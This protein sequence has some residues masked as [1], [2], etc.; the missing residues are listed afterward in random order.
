[1]IEKKSS[2]CSPP[3]AT[4]QSCCNG[5]SQSPVLTTSLS[6]HDRFGNCM[7]R[8]SN[9]FRMH[10]SVTP[11]LYAVGKPGTD[12]PVLV[13]ANY[14]LSVNHV[15]AVLFGRSIWLLVLDTKGINVWCAAGKGT[16]GTDELIQR[17]AA[18]NLKKY[19]HHT[20]IILPQLG[21]PGIAAHRVARETGFNVKY[22]PVYASDIPAYLDNGNAVTPAMR[23]VR[24]STIDRMKLIPME[25]FPAVKECTVFIIIMA[26]LFGMTRSGI[27]YKQAL[28]G[29]Y[30]LLMATI[31]A[32]VTGSFLV[33]L[34][35]PLIPF[36]AFTIKG[37]LVGIAGYAGLILA[38][39]VYRTN[40]YLCAVCAVG[41]PMYSSYR[42]FLFTGS[43]TYTGPSGVK[44]ELK[45]AWPVYR[46]GI[47]VVAAGLVLVL[48]HH[49][50][51]L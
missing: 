4:K 8:L 25:V 33:P 48:L 30:P 5:S 28:T 21:A 42:A 2:C 37:L 44:K 41:V 16:F 39:P 49:W 46:I 20:T 10:Y 45:A 12:D 40:P 29:V 27:M 22:G 11:G 32:V 38:M 34:L 31:A 43:T 47:G 23:H 9:T 7:C 24:F 18:T 3:S 6:L 17:I 19:V 26:L 1:M 51:V 13:T 36:R 15:R 35:L 50:S 14:R